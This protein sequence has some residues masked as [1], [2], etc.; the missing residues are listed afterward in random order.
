M[1]ARWERL[2]CFGRDLIALVAPIIAATI[3]AYQLSFHDQ[4]NRAQVMA[5]LV[6]NRSELTT[7]QLASAFQR[8]GAFDTSGACSAEAKA[9]MRQVDLSSSLLQGVGYVEGDQLWCSSLAETG[10]VDVGAA[11]YVS[12][13]NT[14]IRRQRELPIAPGTPLLLVSATTGYTGLVHPALI[15]SLTSHQHDL[16][17]GTVNYSTRTTIIHS[18]TQTFDWT[19]ANM[20]ETA[21]AGTLVMDGQLLAWKRSLRWDQ[22]AYAAVPVTSVNEQFQRLIGWFLLAG[23]G[24]GIGLLMFVRWLSANRTSLPALLKAGIARGEVFT[25]YQPIVDMRTGR[26]VGAE[27]LARWR[28]PSGEMIAPDVFVPIAEK[29]GLS[30]ML[31]RHVM[32]KC[33]EDLRSLV[34]IDRDFF[35]SVNITSM[36][37]QE[38]EFVRQL[39]AEC[40]A[41]GIAAHRVH[42]EITERAEVDP[43]LAA[44]S[45]SLLRQQGFEIGIDDFG[46]G[47]SNLAY[48]NTLQIDYLK[49]DKAFVAS[50]SNGAIGSAV[51]D[52]IIQIGAERGLTIIAEGVELEAQREAL[53]ARQVRLGQGWLFAR[54]MPSAELL[55]ACTSDRSSH[56]IPKVA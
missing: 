7:D 16:P 26:W 32:M 33:A 24:A 51:V 17:A 13:T 50:P 29:Y 49:I 35:V 43:E 5:D 34:Q 9:L 23:M 54:P 6:L 14:I 20:P 11:D 56:P 41:R 44:E 12:A 1:P 36:D 52:H 25:V 47:Y 2:V 39:I 40:D 15:F 31:T 22:F 3:L 55:A 46:I 45:I 18:S 48:F 10:S 28:R 19:R 4:Q 42:L 38:P 21:F 37:L 53:V 27:V 30:R 8:L